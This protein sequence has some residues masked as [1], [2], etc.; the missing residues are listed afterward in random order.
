V[1]SNATANMIAVAGA[2]AWGTALANVMARNGW[3]V[4]LWARDA[5]QAAHMRHARTND[6]RRASSFTKTLSQPQACMT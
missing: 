6:K 2:G 5:E 3:Q 1:T 4:L